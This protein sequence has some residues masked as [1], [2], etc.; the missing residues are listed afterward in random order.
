MGDYEAARKTCEI[1]PADDLSDACLAVT[2]RKLGRN[3]DAEA[4]LRSLQSLEGDSGA[5][6]YATI[7]S[8]WGEVAKALEWLDT[9]VRLRDAGLVDLKVEPELDPVR[10]EPRFQAIERELA[11]PD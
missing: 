2:Y 6:D 3:A 1:P 10:E 4:A 8:Q 9:A 7:Y 5:Y 11:F